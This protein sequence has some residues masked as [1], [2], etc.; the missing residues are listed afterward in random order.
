MSTSITSKLGFFNTL[1]GYE[2]DFY[3]VDNNTFCIG[4]EGK[5][6]AFEV[7]ED[8]SDGYRSYLESVRVSTKGLI[9]FANALCKV[10][11]T[12]L[13]HKE[14]NGYLFTDTLTGHIWLR[15][16]TDYTDDYYPIFTFNYRPP[17]EASKSQ[18]DVTN[19]C[20]CDSCY[21]FRKHLNGDTDT[22]VDY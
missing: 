17:G 16:G 15:F 2:Y 4:I 1:V 9:Y 21:Y 5:R 3:G 22:D 7:L 14:F 18:G 10:K 20:N 8:E 11:I 12:E 6:C 19:E 13:A